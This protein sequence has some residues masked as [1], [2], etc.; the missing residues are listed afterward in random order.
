MKKNEVTNKKVVS[1][2]MIG[3]SAMMALQTPIT[4]YANDNNNGEAPENG[5]NEPETTQAA[6]QEAAEEYQAVTEEAQSFADTAQESAVEESTS[7]AVEATQ[8]ADLILNGDPDAGIEAVAPE[9]AG[10]Q[11]GEA[12]EKLQEAA[13][14][15]TQNVTEADGTESQAAT[16]SL[17]EAAET[18]KEVKENLVV[19][20]EAN[21]EAEKQYKVVEEESKEAVED[22]K[23]ILSTANDMKEET[24][25][26]SQKAADLVDAIQSAEKIE[27][28]EKAYEDLEKL[29]EDTKSD[30]DARKAL[31]DRL[32]AEYEAAVKKLEEAQTALEKAEEKFDTK[33][34]EAQTGAQEAQADVS[35]AQQ[36]VDNLADALDLVQDKLEDE[37][38][39]NKLA[40]IMG[41]NNDNAWKS[42]LG[43]VT[44]NRIV[45]RN[46]IVNYYMPE[47]LGIEVIDDGQPI[48]SHFEAVSGADGQEYNY[49]K[50]TYQYKD[51]EGNIVEGVKYFNWDSIA[52]LSYNDKDLGLS[53]KEAMVIFEKTEDE[54]AADKLVKEYY[55]T[56]DKS[57]LTN[58]TKK[59]KAYA[60]GTFNVYVY[61]DDEGNKKY[62]IQDKI[63]N[64]DENVVEFDKDGNPVSYNGHSLTQVIQNQNNLLHEA[65]CIIVGSNK[66]IKKYTQAESNTAVYNN[67]IKDKLSDE[68]V[69]EIIDKSMA[70]NTFVTENKTVSTSG[71]ST[72]KLIK[73]YAQYKEATLEAKQ[74]AQTA[75]E[76]ADNLADA[77]DT[78]KSKS[79]NNK[80]SFKAVD[81]L[82]VSDVAGYLGIK[83]DETEAARLN[84]MTM[85]QLINELNKLKKDADDV[86]LEAQNKY[87]DLQEKLTDAS[88]DLKKTQARLTPAPIPSEESGGGSGLLTETGIENSEEISV[89]AETA[90]A[91]SIANVVSVGNVEA[92]QYEEEI[93]VGVENVNVVSAANAGDGAAAIQNEASAPEIDASEVTIEDEETALASSIE[94]KVE[95]AE[96]VVN[97][98]EEDTAL[99]AFAETGT[100]PEKKSW[101]WLLIIAVLGA[102]GEKMYKNYLEKKREQE[103]DFE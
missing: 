59:K 30:L 46:V 79:Q 23:E 10:T 28:A 26:A 25:A 87:T 56:K 43:N 81:V 36:K 49:H 94:E 75:K 33:I 70:L 77:I 91:A 88:N 62:V 76:N 72:T 34:N 18:I 57:M 89:V 20:E 61:L 90:A 16:A 101:W 84:D 9:E 51:E 3:I 38:S 15:I 60:D 40:T 64:P 19:A 58:N 5:N 1:A 39:A 29:V 93:V 27:D 45:M 47:I 13:T 21:K 17:A 85:K 8:A 12:I 65:N 42:S 50:Y 66:Y 6:P 48:E 32:S 99:A 83:V 55:G 54:V 7:A 102:T 98:E 74:A 11:A 82:K 35:A 68:K 4:A 92:A 80:R 97:I 67:I 69:Q 53:N 22:A 31:Y 14:A 63:L 100:V 24:E 71:T 41:Q 96:T 95:E 44:A 2:L 78:I 86:A 73:Q 103:D 37:D 52:K